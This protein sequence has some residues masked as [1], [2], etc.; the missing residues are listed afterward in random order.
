MKL[1]KI[2]KIVAYFSIAMALSLSLFSCQDEEADITNP[3]P[4]D[5]LDASSRLVLLINR[6]VTDEDIDFKIEC[7][8]FE[9]PISISIFDTDFDIART[10]EIESDAQFS[11]FLETLEEENLI[12]SINYP[13]TTVFTGESTPIEISDNLGL[14]NTLLEGQGAN[15]NEPITVQDCTQTNTTENLKNCKWTINRYSINE[16]FESYTITFNEGATLSISNNADI[17]YTGDWE[18]LE[19]DNLLKLKISTQIIDFNWEIIECGEDFLQAKS[20]DGT[21]ILAKDCTVEVENPEITAA[22]ELIIGCTWLMDRYIVDGDSPFTDNLNSRTF[23]F[24]DQGTFVFSDAGTLYRGEWTFEKDAN[25]NLV[26]ILEPFQ[27]L[28]EFI[29]YDFTMDTFRDGFML[30]NANTNDNEITTGFEQVCL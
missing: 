29:D 10:D 30:W 26:L 20:D 17:T 25:D 4:T 16:D 8:D 19:E 24:N 7:L 18:V 2:S 5:V 23:E 13:I 9:Y 28:P 14:E 21:I 1:I 15:C 12:A 3:E 11:S 27:S 6:T 22:K